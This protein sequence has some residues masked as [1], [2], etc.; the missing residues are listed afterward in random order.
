[1]LT[2]DGPCR[3]GLLVCEPEERVSTMSSTCVALDNA[4]SAAAPPALREQRGVAL[5]RLR[6][7]S[8]VP[9]RS[10]CVCVCVCACVLKSRS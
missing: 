1:M 8:R 3:T 5:D 6:P 2:W 10:V 7:T 4:L 9:A